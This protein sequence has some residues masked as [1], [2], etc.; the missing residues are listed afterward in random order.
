MAAD[1][2]SMVTGKVATPRVSQQ[3]MRVAQDPGVRLAMHEGHPHVKPLEEKKPSGICPQKRNTPRAPD[4]VYNMTNPL[5]PTRENIDAGEMLFKIDARPTACKVCHGVRGNGLGIIFK[6]LPT[7]PR[8]FTC[9]YT[10][11]GIPDGQMFWIIKNG[12][13]G[14]PMPAFGSLSDRQVWQLVLFVRQ[15]LKKNQP[16]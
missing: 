6:N 14:T 8:N 7:K 16:E 12:S 3:E 15:F 1:G 10:M 13:P 11:E 4:P 2:F 5:L 9:Y